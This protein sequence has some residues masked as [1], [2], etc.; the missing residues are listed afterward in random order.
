MVAGIGDARL[1]HGGAAQGR[2]NPEVGY[3]H[4]AGILAG[5][6]RGYGIAGIG[7]ILVVK[8]VARKKADA[9]VAVDAPAELVISQIEVCT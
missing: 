3:L 4:P 5:E 6:G 8:V 2:G 9:G 1:V 7:N